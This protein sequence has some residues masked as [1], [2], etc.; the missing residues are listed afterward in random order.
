MPDSRPFHLLATALMAGILTFCLGVFPSHS[1]SITDFTFTSIDGKPMPLSAY[2]GK[3]VLVV[4]TASQCGFTPQYAGLQKLWETYRDRGL[5]LLAVPSND[6]G[7]QEPGSSKEIK[8]FCESTFGTDFPMTEK[9][10]V[11]GD[12]AHPFYRW[13]KASLGDQGIPKWNFH[14]LLIGPDGQLLG[15]FASRITPQSPE[16]T[17]AIEGHLP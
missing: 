11:K 17:A 16:L 13:A 7:G 5:V 2:R 9:V 3:T 8:E 12:G 6:F 15:G 4:N 14:K 1:A 10:V